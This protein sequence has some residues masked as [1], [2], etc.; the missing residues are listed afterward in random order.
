[1]HAL[2]LPALGLHLRFL[3]RVATSNAGISTLCGS[4]APGRVQTLNSLSHLHG[5]VAGSAR[6]LGCVTV[7]PRRRAS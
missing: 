7:K 5:S 3:H 2:V 1:V 4:K 6:A